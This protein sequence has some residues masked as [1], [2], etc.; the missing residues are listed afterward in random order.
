MNYQSIAKV[1]W[2]DKQRQKGRE[3]DAALNVAPALITAGT[4]VQVETE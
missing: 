3:R 4:I 1:V 2:G